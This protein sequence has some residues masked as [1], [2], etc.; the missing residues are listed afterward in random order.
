MA[1]RFRNTI[2]LAP[3]IRLNLGR[4]GVSLSAGVRG[5]SVTLGKNG[6]WG[7]VGAPGTGMSYRTRLS[8]SPSHQ[9]RA[10]RELQRQSNHAASSAPELTAFKAILDERGQVSLVDQEGQPLSASQH[11]MVWS[12]YADRMTTWLQSEMDTING[13]MELLLDIHQDIVPPG[14]AIPD[15]EPEAFEQPAPIKPERE[16]RPPRPVKPE[17]D[18]SFWDRLIPGRQQ[19]LIQAQE[20]DLQ[21][22]AFE[23]EAWKDQCLQIDKAYEQRLQQYERQVAEWNRAWEAHQQ[24][25][26]QLAQVFTERLTTD[27]GLVVEILTAE[28]NDLD[29]PRETLV[30]FDIDLASQGVYLD[31]DLPEIEDIP[32]RSAEFGARN[33][34][35]LIK[36]KSDRQRRE[37]YARHVH[38]IILRLAG[39]VLGLL[40]GIERV[41][42]SGYS[43]R[44]DSATGH[45]NDDY[46]LS[47]A[48]DKAR[49]AELNFEQ[50]E[51]VDPIAAL[52][53]FDLRREMTKTGIFRPV[54]PID[55][56]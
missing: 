49:F 26:T 47:V 11:R 24:E 33:R 21:Q 23:L 30:D 7:N 55:P 52:E 36:D 51:Q 15:Y 37:E 42:V 31:V 39:V 17:L 13:D 2:R 12:D 50:L 16:R 46:L 8:G 14:S 4:R 1:F 48:I 3:G 40:P 9:R 54:V 45:I 44:L 29:W 56:V 34:R 10:Q 19:R 6:L 27:E 5:A 38:G 43:Q 35:L 22:W 20:Q 32:A 41:V 18:V 25:Q 53:R 28:L